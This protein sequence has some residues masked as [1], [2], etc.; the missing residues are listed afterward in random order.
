MHTQA[1]TTSV[2]VIEPSVLIA[3][4]GC[5]TTSGMETTSTLLLPILGFINAISNAL[6]VSLVLS[7]RPIVFACVSNAL[8]AIAARLVA[9]VLVAE[10]AGI[11]RHLE[12]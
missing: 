4:R 3:M 12:V 6:F 2:K 1:P 7:T 5:S 10:V 8:G 11:A 9:A